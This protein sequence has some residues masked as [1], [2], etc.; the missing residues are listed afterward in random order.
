[1]FGKKKNKVG[2]NAKKRTRQDI[3]REYAD[4]AV[5]VG[6]KAR[7]VSQ[8]QEEIDRHLARMN[9]C[10]REVMLLPADEKQ[11]DGQTTPQQAQPQ[12]PPKQEASRADGA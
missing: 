11:P 4:Q 5:Q 3:E 9:S 8:F 12:T 7:M 10:N 2:F 1:M 6:H